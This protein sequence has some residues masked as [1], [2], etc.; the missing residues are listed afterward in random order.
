MAA[1]VFLPSQKSSEFVPWAT[2]VLRREDQLKDV[3]QPALVSG[4]FDECTPLVAKTFYDKLANAEGW[5]LI[6]NGTHLCNVEFPEI[7]NKA[8]EEFIERHE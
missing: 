2:S 6:E 5:L 8:V 3:K 1:H 4:E 7:Y